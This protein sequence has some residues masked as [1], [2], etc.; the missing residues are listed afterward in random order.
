MALLADGG[1]PMNT[2]RSEEENAAV[3]LPLEGWPTMMNTARYTDYVPLQ[4][5]EPAAYA[6]DIREVLAAWASVTPEA[7]EASNH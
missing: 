6:D 4:D 7:L 5:G 1:D 2:I 3:T